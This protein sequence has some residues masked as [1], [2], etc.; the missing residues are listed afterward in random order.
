MIYATREKDEITIFRFT[1]ELSKHKGNV[2]DI[3]E[4]SI[5]TLPAFIFGARKPFSNVSVTF[6]KF[7]VIQ[8]LN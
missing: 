8:H 6:D 3:S 2:N 1:E 7:H 5:D 4:I